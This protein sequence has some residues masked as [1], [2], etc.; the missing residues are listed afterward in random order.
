MLGLIDQRSV[1]VLPIEI[2]LVEAWGLAWKPRPVLQ[3]YA[4]SRAR[5]D[6]KDAAFFAGPS[7]P[8]R[9]LVELRGLDTRHPFMDSPLTWREI[10]SR[11]DPLGWD[12]RF[13]LLARREI[14]RQVVRREVG[15]AVSPLNAPIEIPETAA[16]HLE[17]ELEISPTL[18]GRLVALPWKLPEIRLGVASRQD[19]RP[20]RIVADNVR[21]AFPLVDPWPAAPVDLGRLF[22]GRKIPAPAGLALLSRGAWAWEEATVRFFE[23]R[24]AESPPSAAAPATR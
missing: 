17:I 21:H 10:L 18:R 3:G 13:L 4:V 16:G 23:V 2:A 15:T 1:D 14:P 8:E 11:Y 12:N 7:A 20:R 5:L 22:T 19:P 6:A 9:L 24:W